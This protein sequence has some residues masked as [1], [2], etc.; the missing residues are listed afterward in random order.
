MLLEQWLSSY[1][2]I[3]VSSFVLVSL[4]A[5]FSKA[6]LFFPRFALTL[7]NITGALVF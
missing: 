1:Y 6:V 5:K 2:L 4:F 3:I 7:Q